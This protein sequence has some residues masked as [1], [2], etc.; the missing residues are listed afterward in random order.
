MPAEACAAQ[1]IARLKRR[2][3]RERASRLEAETIAEKGLRE[4]YEGL[5]IDRSFVSRMGQAPESM[6]IVGTIMSLARNLGMGVVAEGAEAEAQVA[7]LAAMG[8]DFGQGYVFSKPV[9]AETATGL[10][11]TPPPPRGRRSPPAAARAPALAV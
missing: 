3:E 4:L 6:Q 2:L 8:C 1:E 5:K 11:R 7:Q 10:L 9:D